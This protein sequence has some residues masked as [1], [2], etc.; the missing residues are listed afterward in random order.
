MKKFL[1]KY[2]LWFFIFT[3]PYI[4]LLF[5]LVIPTNYEAIVPY[6]LNNVADNI[7]LEGKEDFNDQSFYTISVTSL[8]YVTPFQKL[9]IDSLNIGETSKKSS[10]YQHL[11]TSDTTLMGQ[12]E[13]QSSYQTSI[14]SAFRQAQIHDSNLQ[15][16]YQFVGAKIHYIPK[17]LYQSQILKVGDLVT[18][19]Q[20]EG[21]TY[22]ASH[23][24]TLEEVGE[25]LNA[26]HH[27]QF[28]IVVNNQ[29]IAIDLNNEQ[30]YLNIYPFFEITTNPQVLTPGLNSSTGGPSGGLLQG[31]Y[32]YSNLLN[33]NYHHLKISGTGTLEYHSQVGRIGGIKEKFASAI[34]QKVDIFFLPE[35]NFS[36]IADLISK[37]PQIKVYPVLSLE[38]AIA[39]L[40]SELI[41]HA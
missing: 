18:S 11:K 32:L 19:I 26:F 5:I 27:L 3:L 7:Y 2:R 15:L 41:D 29:N 17:N 40:N 6:G 30:Y 12:I 8:N 28:Q 10:S 34:A 23:T 31:L 21:L 13:K 1:K 16:T 22:Q 38:Q 20:V 9:L 37:N 4:Y 25:F 24:T 33:R 35:G 14:I 36:E 39:A